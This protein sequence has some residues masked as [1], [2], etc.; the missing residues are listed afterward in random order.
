MSWIVFIGIAICLF[1][2]GVYLKERRRSGKAYDRLVTLF[3]QEDIVLPTTNDD[4]INWREGSDAL[5]FLSDKL[6]KAGYFSPKERRRARLLMSG[7]LTAGVITGLLI[8]IRF[9]TPIAASIGVFV[10]FYL[11]LTVWVA[12]LSYQRREFERKAIF[13]TPLTLEAI[14]LLVESGLGLLPAIERIV[15]SQDET[16]RRNPMVRMLRLVYELSSHGVPFGLALEMVSDA[17]ELKVLRHV[18]LHL[19]ISGSEGGELIPSLR[20]L[21]NHA[22]TEWKLSVERR[23]RRLENTSV[24]PVFASVMGI[25]MVTVAVPI[26]PILDLKETMQER[27]NFGTPNT[28]NENLKEKNDF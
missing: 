9:G 4:E 27:A 23:V 24:F 20:S 14:I 19:D 16:S 8:G 13:Q 5:K 2:F 11:G 15:S 17:T 3:E 21:S 26:V 1:G 7:L 28:Q 10:G 6:G 25:M 22:H 12:F 18:L